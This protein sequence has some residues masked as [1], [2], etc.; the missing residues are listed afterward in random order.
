[1]HGHHRKQRDVHGVVRVVV[2]DD[3][4]GDVLW[5]HPQLAHRAEDQVAVSHHPRVHDDHPTGLPDEAD[6]PGDIRHSCV[7]L[8]EDVQTRFTTQVRHRPNV[9]PPLPAH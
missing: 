9:A 3:D 8:D 7:P 4:V 5:P 1:M 6:R 2:A